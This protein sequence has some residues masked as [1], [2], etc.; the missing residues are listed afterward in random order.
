[1][2]P[3][4][5]SADEDI[6]CMENTTVFG[7]SSFQYIVL[8]LAFSIGPPYRTRIWNNLPFLFSMIFLTIINSLFLLPPTE[9]IAESMYSGNEI[10]IYRTS[11][12]H[13]N[14]TSDNDI[15]EIIPFSF[16][17]ILFI[18]AAAHCIFALIVEELVKIPAV[19]KFAKRLRGKKLPKNRFKRIELEI[20]SKN[21]WLGK[22]I[23]KVNAAKN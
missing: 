5:I 7:I 11:E 19:Q 8:A 17:W 20:L 14:I 6:I 10:E 12:N 21:S 22:T 3:H 13:V 15:K 16:R 9:R 23:E 4:R 2:I 1:M 18:L